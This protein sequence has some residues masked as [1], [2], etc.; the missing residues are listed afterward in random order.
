MVSSQTTMKTWSY[1]HSKDYLKDY[2]QEGWRYII[3][4]VVVFQYLSGVAY[5]TNSALSVVGIIKRAR[6]KIASLATSRW[7][8]SYCRI[9]RL[10]SV[11]PR[12]SVGRAT[13]DQI[14]RSSWVRFPPRSEI[15]SLPR[16]ISL[17]SLLGLTLSGKFMGL[18]STTT[19]TAELIL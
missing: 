14:P 13:D 4:G 1:I 17:I 10:A 16:A 6:A 8:H 15:F 18:L 12:S 9:T 7:D 5:T 3:R 19:H 11:W 2:F